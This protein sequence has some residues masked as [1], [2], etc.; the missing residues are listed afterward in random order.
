MT[1]LERSNS[2]TDLAARIKAE[3]EACTL[4]IK[5]GLQHAVACGR[6]L[7]E[8]KDLLDHGQWLPWLRDHCQVPERSAQR[9]MDLAVFAA[10]TKSDNLADLALDGVATSSAPLVSRAN[11]ALEAG[12]W[13]RATELMLDAPFNAADLTWE[14]PR[15]W[16]RNKLLHQ[17]RVPAIARWCISVTD[18]MEDNTPEAW[19][20]CP[21]GPL[22]E[23]VK[24]LAP[25]GKR[26]PS[27]IKLDAASFDTMRAMQNAISCLSVEAAVVVGRMLPEIEYRRTISDE[28]Y[29]RECDET[30]ALIESRLLDAI[31]RRGVIM[32]LSWLK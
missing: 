7:I 14:P 19:R 1:D 3:H 11:E 9:Y 29:E 32:D 10:D 18:V 4:A 15:N 6:L 20:I 17:L 16:I 28:Q 25:V 23:T 30:F 27:P 31:V 13:E 26:E 8:A 2:L 5:R 21:C 22:V 12:D 24:L